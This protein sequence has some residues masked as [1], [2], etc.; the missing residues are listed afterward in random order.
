M[1]LHRY[2]S[3]HNLVIL[4]NSLTDML[5]SHKVY[6]NQNMSFRHA[7]HLTA[8]LPRVCDIHQK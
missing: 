7:F 4:L 8:A 6:R 2:L 5:D 1:S 3:I